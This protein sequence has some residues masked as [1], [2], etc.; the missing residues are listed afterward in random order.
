MKGVQYILTGTGLNGWVLR[1]AGC[2]FVCAVFAVCAA[3]GDGARGV[4]VYG[5][6][7]AEAVVAPRSAALSASDLA[8]NGV[9]PI[10]SNPSLAARCAAP[11][12]T[13]AYSSYYG[14][15]FSAS[16]LNYT[17]GAGK[18]GGVSVTAAYLLIPGIEDTRGVDVDAL[19]DGDIKIFSASDVWVRAAYGHGVKTGYADVYAGAAAAF[20]RRG[21]GEASAYGIG[22]DIGVMAFFRK[23]SLY[24]ALLWENVRYGTVKWKEYTEEVPQHLRASLAFERND[25]YIYGRIAVFYTSPD[26]L[27]NEG[28]N[29]QAD[30][31][32]REEGRKPTVR[33][34]SDGAGILF[35]AGRYGIEYTIMNTLSLRAGFSG[36]GY[37]MGAGLN[38]FDGRAGA[39]ICYI[40][41]ELAGTVK[42][43]VTYRW[44]QEQ[45]YKD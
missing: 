12:I 9:G 1:V 7:A 42:V 36:D 16:A 26:L 22:A 44:K 34:L 29:A 21:I 43:S 13:A 30:T 33:T 11:E 23:P 41:H 31:S 37:S 25:P 17:G 20:R 38:L 28:I 24:A 10:A 27:F 35:A 40:G 8:V 2:V 3:D 18:S 4:S 14:G 15:A 45:G 32:D 6:M 39:D 5:D 19:D